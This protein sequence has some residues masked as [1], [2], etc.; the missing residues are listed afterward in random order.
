M[1]F[2]VA[3]LGIDVLP[4]Q[5]INSGSV[6]F[7]GL[8]LTFGVLGLLSTYLGQNLRWAY[9]PAAILLVLGLTDRDAF[10]GCIGVVV[11]VGADRRRRVSDSL[12]RS[13]PV[14]PTL[15]LPR[16][17]VKWRLRLS[18]KAMRLLRRRQRRRQ[19]SV[20]Q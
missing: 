18:Q 3:G 6:L 14:L 5:F 17:A 8:G 11:A 2:S 4:F 9:I 12:R 15:A 13:A 10:C 16:V 19:C 20:N 7:I 1:S